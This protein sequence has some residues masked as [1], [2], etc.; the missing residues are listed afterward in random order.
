MPTFVLGNGLVL[1]VKHL[2]LRNGTYYYWRKIPKHLQARYGGRKLKRV[3]LETSDKLVAAKKASKMAAADEALWKS[4]SDRSDLSPPEVRE[5]AQALIDEL[6]PT[7]WIEP[8]PKGERGVWSRA[9]VLTE[10]LEDDD[11]YGSVVHEEAINLLER[12]KSVPLLSEALSVYL[13]EHKNGKKPKFARETELA[14]GLV[15]K[16]LGDRPID[17]YRRREVAEW[18]DALLSQMTTV[19]FK[20]RLA[21][22]KAVL[23]KALIEFEITVSNPFE[24]LTIPNEGHDSK[25]RAPFTLSELKLISDKARDADDDL[26]W[27]VAL[28]IETGARLGE[29]VGL[30]LTDIDLGPTPCIKIRPHE[31]RSLKTRQ[32]EREV[33][34]VGVSLWAAQR[35]FQAASCGGAGSRPWLFPRYEGSKATHASNAINKWLRPLSGG[36]TSHSF[37]HSLR[38]RLRA[39][40]CPEAIAEQVGGWGSRSVSQGYGK[41]YPLEVLRDWL[42]RICLR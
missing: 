32:S 9:Q 22:I 1:M 34:L 7:E 15:T 24:R 19:T 30:R 21:S 35:A 37:R 11:R 12:D 23:N 26:R 29:L 17:S 6:R 16:V 2:L 42:L 27:L 20:R 31:K 39:A 10:L 41:G 18:R 3:S 4:M 5:A 14:I 8:G 33:P 40:Q 25:E 36:K 28:Q 38:D 13:A